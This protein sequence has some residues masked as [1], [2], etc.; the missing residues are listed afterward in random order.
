MMKKRYLHI[1]L[2]G[3][4]GLL[5][6]TASAERFKPVEVYTFSGVCSDCTGT[7]TGTLVLTSDFVLGVSTIST[8]NFVSFTYSGTDLL[9]A[10]TISSGDLGLSVSGT[11]AGSMPASYA[12]VHLSNRS[13]SFDTYLQPADGIWVAGF[14]KKFGDQ[15]NTY[16][17]N[18]AS[19]SVPEP[20]TLGLIGAGLA[21]LAVVGLRRKRR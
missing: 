19:T 6:V 17:W 13:F 16:S 15:G 3:L 7:A 4:A 2:L 8:S 14:N 11:F 18:A 9:P 5:T 1:A 12:D 10:F 20:A 21:G